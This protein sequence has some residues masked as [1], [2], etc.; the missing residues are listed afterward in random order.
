M[1]CVGYKDP[2]LP[3]ASDESDRDSVDE[4]RGRDG[5]RRSCKRSGGGRRRSGRK[6]VRTRSAARS[7]SPPS[8]ALTAEEVE[9]GWSADP[10][11]PTTHTF[12]ATPGMAVP[13]PPH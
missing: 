9:Q 7:G 2:P 6:G 12:T 8:Y 10:T 1:T 3:V 13:Q 5:N 11:P 4:E